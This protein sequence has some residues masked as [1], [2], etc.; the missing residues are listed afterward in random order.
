MNKRVLYIT[1]YF[2]DSI[3]IGYRHSN[4]IKYSK[5]FLDIDLLNFESAKKKITFFQKVLNKLF[6]YP[7]LYYF[8]LF[9]Y[10]RQ[11]RKKLIQSNYDI[12]IIGVLPFSFLNLAS[13]IKQ[14]QPNLKVIIDM[15]DPLTANVSYIND[16]FFHR[17]FISWYEQKHFKNIDILIVLNEE[18]KEYYQKKYS[19]IKSILVLEQGT[20]PLIIND[21]EEKKSNILEVI[22]AG[23]FYKKVR[24][25]FQ[26]YNA[27]VQYSGNIRLS[28]YGSFK[29]IFLP[30]IN[31]RFY[32]A[33][34]VDR[35]VVNN[36]TLE[37]DIIVFLDNFFG[38]QI[39]GKILDCLATK[40]PI[41]FVFENEQS[42][43]LK[44]VKDFEGVFYSK[45]NAKEIIKQLEEIALSIDHKYNRDLTKYYWENLVNEK[46]LSNSFFVN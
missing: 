17:R 38:L 7:D 18:I 25:P 9:K 45:N 43:T 44:Y 23:M 36:K 24:E 15:S 42:P 12:V 28:V 5:P 34:Y 3:T 1:K 16:T 46:L 13:F 41:L 27:I 19:F 11:I 21:I 4:I 33:G 32:Y 37:S 29:K 22:Y 26:L 35:E 6:I 8:N 31:E 14:Q 10:K 20:N 2:D 30:P 40:K 39:P